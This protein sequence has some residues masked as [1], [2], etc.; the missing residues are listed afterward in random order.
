MYQYSFEQHRNTQG[1]YMSKQL[2]QHDQSA[3]SERS[4]RK[5]TKALDRDARTK[6]RSVKVTEAHRTADDKGLT[7]DDRRK[8]ALRAN[9][10]EASEGVGLKAA[11]ASG[12]KNAEGVKAQDLGFAGDELSQLRIT[13]AQ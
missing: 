6:A 1:E 2:S 4:E 13:T 5:G 7:A 12:N 10:H 3:I 8:D 11:S 9:G